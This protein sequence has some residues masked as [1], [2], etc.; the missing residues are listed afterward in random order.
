MSA[1]TAP[2]PT[3]RPPTVFDSDCFLRWVTTGRSWFLVPRK[4]CGDPAL[5]IV[6]VDPDHPVCSQRRCFSAAAVA[7]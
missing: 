1:D 2:H 7:V 5:G 3:R 4:L 6:G